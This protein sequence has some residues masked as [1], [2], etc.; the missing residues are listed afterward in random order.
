M[1]DEFGQRSNQPGSLTLE[2]IHQVKNIAHLDKITLDFESPRMK[3]AAEDLGINTKELVKR[4][5]WFQSQNGY[6]I[7]YN[8]NNYR[9]RAY[10]E[11]NQKDPDIVDLR[12]NHYSKKLIEDLNSILVQRKKIIARQN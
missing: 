8:N 2:K 1:F 9:D 12:Y 5:V 7:F 4:Y 11:K 10:F 6:F 3:Q